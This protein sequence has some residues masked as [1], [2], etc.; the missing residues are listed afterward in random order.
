M[1]KDYDS[2]HLETDR[3]RFTELDSEIQRQQAIARYRRLKSQEKSELQLDD[4]LFIDNFESAMHLLWGV[5]IS[6]VTARDQC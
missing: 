4:Q 5:P 2:R 1:Q 3:D 6:G